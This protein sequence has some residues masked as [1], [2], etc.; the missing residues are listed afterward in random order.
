MVSIDI[1]Y[2]YILHFHHYILLL[3][4]SI[5]LCHQTHNFSNRIISIVINCL[6]NYLRILCV[7]LL[8][9]QILPYLICLHVSVIIPLLY[10][11]IVDV[12]SFTM[13]V[14][15]RNTSS[16]SLGSG[17]ADAS[18]MFRCPWKSSAFPRLCR[19]LEIHRCLEREI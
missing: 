8:C 14:V 10:T 9:H 17:N 5:L 2:S 4:F 11:I 18:A 3:L 12:L 19:F 15:A 16:V 13:A 7:L 6:I 1:V